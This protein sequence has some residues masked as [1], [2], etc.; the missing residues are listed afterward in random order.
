MKTNFM[1]VEN[2]MHRRQVIGGLGA[3]LAAVTVTPV[4]RFSR[5][6][7]KEGNIRGSCKAG[8]KITETSFPQ[9]GTALAGTGE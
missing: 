8:N 1:K 6:K 3:T 9:S 5:N 2:K 7:N 4:F